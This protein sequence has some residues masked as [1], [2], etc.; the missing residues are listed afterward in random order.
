MR[1][2]PCQLYFLNKTRGSN[3]PKKRLENPKAEKSPITVR[4]A[5]KLNTPWDELVL[6]CIA[7]PTR[8][9]R[10]PGPLAQKQQSWWHW[11]DAGDEKISR[12]AARGAMAV[13]PESNLGFVGAP[14]LSWG[15]GRT[16][17][18]GTMEFG[19]PDGTSGP[20]RW[21]VVPRPSTR[22]TCGNLRVIPDPEGEG[23]WW[24]AGCC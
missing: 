4:L 10:Q 18:D 5:A 1:P 15:I 12:R 11:R 9:P 17:G 23:G 16:V 22:R 20:G 13:A 7:R 19:W 6:S 24:T 8:A 2:Y 14:A 3:F 21:H